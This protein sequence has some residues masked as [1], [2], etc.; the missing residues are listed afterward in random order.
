VKFPRNGYQRYTTA[1]LGTGEVRGVWH[2]VRADGTNDIV[3]ACDS[4]IYR[5]KATGV[6]VSLATGLPGGEDHW[7]GV[8][9]LNRLFL[10]HPD[11][12]PQIYDTALEVLEDQDGA[13]LPSVWEEGNRP[14]H[15]GLVAS[16]K[17]E[18]LAAWGFA[19]DPSRAY[20]CARKDYLDWTT[21]GN[22]F[23]IAALEEDGERLIAVADF[24][25]YLL[26]MKETRT[27]IFSGVDPSTG[28]ADSMRVIPFGCVAP[29]SVGKTGN[30]LWWM[31]KEGPISLRAVENY[32]ELA[33]D[34]L[35]SRIPTTIGDMSPVHLGQ[36]VFV[37]DRRMKR[38]SWFVPTRESVQNT[39]RL[40]Y[41]YDRTVTDHENRAMGSWMRCEGLPA[42]CAVDIE[43]AGPRMIITGGYDGWLNQMN[44]MYQD[45]G[46]D[47]VSY[48]H[49]ADFD[50]K[51]RVRA[52]EIDVLIE[53]G[54]EHIE[55]SMVFDGT[56]RSLRKTASGPNVTGK[57]HPYYS[58]VAAFGSGHTLQFKV[59]HKG[60]DA[61]AVFSGIRAQLDL[62]GR[63]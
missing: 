51:V 56:E 2:L 44:F 19:E 13:D 32:G 54:G 48:F 43:T 58:R 12:K 26:M 27:V 53:S 5:I 11:H 10:V 6:P 42:T 41:Y 40:D 20:F 62:L 18:R 37:H 4:D 9:Y 28:V 47:I 33:A 50:Y 61:Q 15:I 57:Q 55:L 21:D 23:S 29:R 46:A 30:D 8:T 38:I 59:A 1:A 60:G 22:A 35:K 25:T 36:C 45:N 3:A 24:G 52:P 14:R 7:S 39:M 31:S 34:Y 17:N 49:S 63:P 16:G